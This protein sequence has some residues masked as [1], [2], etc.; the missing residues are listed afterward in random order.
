MKDGNNTV[1]YAIV[2]KTCISIYSIYIYLNIYMIY[3]SAFTCVQ[4]LN[5]DITDKSQ[6]SALM[7]KASDSLKDK[8]LHY[9]LLFISNVNT[10]LH[11]ILQHDVIFSLLDKH[12]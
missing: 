11:V 7:I 4:S 10:P 1:L 9:L 2:K 5:Q 3:I 8:C 6:I 12:V